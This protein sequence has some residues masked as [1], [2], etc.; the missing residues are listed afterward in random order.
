[1]TKLLVYVM[2][3]LAEASGVATTV[4]WWYA[5]AYTGADNRSLVSTDAQDLSTTF[6]VY[7]DLK[8]IMGTALTETAG[9]LAAAFKRWFNVAA[10]TGTVNSI[11]DAVAGADNGLALKGSDMNASK[12][13]G[14]TLDVSAIAGNLA[15]NSYLGNSVGFTTQQTADV[16]TRIPQV[17]SMAQLGGT[18]AWYVKG[19]TSSGLLQASQADVLSVVTPKL[20]VVRQV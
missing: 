18:G 9:Y 5:A 10:P 20:V 17:I 3:S 7:A 15:I 2:S 14:K 4:N 13:G 8:A 12:I 16:G 1:M 19:L 11:P 6:K